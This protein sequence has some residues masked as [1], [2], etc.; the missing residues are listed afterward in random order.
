M[1]QTAMEQIDLGDGLCE[2]DL[3]DGTVQEPAFKLHTGDDEPDDERQL[4]ALPMIWARLWTVCL[5]W[6]LGFYQ[7]DA[8]CLQDAAMRLQLGQ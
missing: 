1:V 8:Q 4:R 3:G 7:K 5:P 2:L 6:N